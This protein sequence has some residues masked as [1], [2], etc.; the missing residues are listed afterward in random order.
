MVQIPLLYDSM[1]SPSLTQ[2]DKNSHCSALIGPLWL[3]NKIYISHIKGSGGWGRGW[4]DVL[5]ASPFLLWKFSGRTM[6]ERE[7]LAPLATISSPLHLWSSGGLLFF[8][9]KSLS[10]KV[11]LPVEKGPGWGEWWKL[12]VVTFRHTSMLTLSF[13]LLSAGEN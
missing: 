8:H 3:Q 7:C 9:G 10:Q 4:I 2:L 13:H 12:A 6:K 5:P 1:E 11:T